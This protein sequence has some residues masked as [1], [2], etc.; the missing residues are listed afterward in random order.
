MENKNHPSETLPI[1]NSCQTGLPLF[2]GGV[3]YM[4]EEIWRDIPNYEG[5]Y[6]VSSLGRIMSIPR[7]VPC[8][9]GTNVTTRRILKPST[10]RFG[11]QFVAIS[12]C[13]VLKTFKLHRLVAV[14]F[15]ENVENSIKCQVNHINGDKTDNRLVN[16]EIVSPRENVAAY[17]LLKNKD[18]K[19]TGVS[20]RKDCD[21]WLAKATIGKKQYYLGLHN[22]EE[23]AYTAYKLFLKNIS[24][25][26]FQK[27]LSSF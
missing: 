24:E 18:K 23:D 7:V 17:H 13:G 11:Y 21:K 5:M 4:E 6:Q 22:T 20:K 19:Y 8:N 15:F 1:D 26:Q 2:S 3:F 14:S 12:K 10:N 9:T 16:L 27:N 25:E